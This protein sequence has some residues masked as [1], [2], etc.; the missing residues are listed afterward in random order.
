M[1]VPVF[2]VA[3]PSYYSHGNFTSFVRQL[4]NYGRRMRV[5]VPLVF[6]F[7]WFILLFT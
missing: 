6:F 2:E 3:L 4:N 5:L 1:Q 7:V